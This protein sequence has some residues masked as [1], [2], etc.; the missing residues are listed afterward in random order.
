MN[1]FKRALAGVL[2]ACTVLTSFTACGEKTGVAM[3]IDGKD[4]PAGV[5]LYYVTLAYNDAMTAIEETEKDKFSECKTTADIKKIMKASKIDDKDAEKWIEDKAVESC[6]TYV[7]TL[8]EFDNLGL[9]LTG[10]ELANIDSSVAG[11]QSYYGEFFKENGIGEKSVKEIL[12]LSYKQNAIYEAY[13]SDG[14]SEGVTDEELRTYYQDN[15]LR[16]KYIEMPLKD[17]EGN[18]LKADG[19]QEIENMANDFI[20]RLEKKSDDEKALMKEFDY[21]IEENNAYITSLSEAAVTTTDENGQT[22]TTLTT[23][24]VTT[25]EDTEEGTTA[26]AD[27]EAVEGT[28]APVA[29][30]AADTTTTVTAGDTAEGTTTTA[31]TTTA[32]S[33]DTAAGTDVTTVTAGES[34][35][36]TTTMVTVSVGYD[37]SYE[38]IVHIVTTSPEEDEKPEESE[39][40]VNYTPCKLVYDYVA[41]SASPY[42]KPTLIKDEETY[43]VVAKLDIKDR[44]TEDDIWT[45]SEKDNTR[46]E[47]YYEVFMDKLTE[48]G[49]QLT[50]V[51]NEKAFSRYNVLDVDVKAYN[52]AT[53]QS[54]YDYYMAQQQAANGMG[55]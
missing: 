42:L 51:R 2:T 35:T 38:N 24:K 44:M 8:K 54:Y 49:K 14:G 4:I 16:M 52:A 47:K 11:S 1:L 41:D 6:Q 7:A 22:I 19:K 32:A 25:A 21:L 45:E 40:T 12:T 37:I 30:N 17:G 29:E 53:Q 26:P 20:K 3:T 28:T 34:T 31:P 43:Y 46:Y 13:Y 15:H 36:T 39:T 55:Y 48:M 18:L 10:E 5:Y 9:S 33:D 50:L 23:A 27:E